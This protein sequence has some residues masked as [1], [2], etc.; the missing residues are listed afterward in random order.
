ME[1]GAP[2]NKPSKSIS[3]KISTLD[4]PQNNSINTLEYDGIYSSKA[5]EAKKGRRSVRKNKQV[6]KNASE[7]LIRQRKT[8]V[9]DRELKMP[10]LGV[11]SRQNMYQN[12]NDRG[13]LKESRNSSL[14][15]INSNDHIHSKSRSRPKQR[16]TKLI[17]DKEKVNSILKILEK[18]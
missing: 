6:H 14:V 5:E 8:P 12:I 16:Q 3:N 18:K 1:E 17:D 9:G 4:T 11:D 2:S 10:N 13:G 7:Q 15:I